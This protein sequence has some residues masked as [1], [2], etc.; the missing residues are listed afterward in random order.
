MLKKN[1]IDST[2]REYADIYTRFASFS[3]KNVSFYL[4]HTPTS[5]IN[6]LW[7][8]NDKQSTFESF[9]LLNSITFKK[10]KGQRGHINEINQIT[11]KFVDQCVSNKRVNK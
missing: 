11:Q 2:Q 10:C 5:G 7:V 8:D 4:I 9:C 1:Y 3:N 6:S